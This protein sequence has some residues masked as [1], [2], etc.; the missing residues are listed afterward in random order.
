[1]RLMP[2]NW[3]SFQHYKDRSP[4]WIK[5]HR[6]LLDSIDYHNLSPEA[7]KHLPLIWLLASERD[8]VLPDAD[9]VAFRFRITEEMAT[10]ILDELL[11]LDF[12]VEVDADDVDFDSP[13]TTSKKIAQKNGFGSRHIKDKTKKEIFERD[14]GCC[15]E[16]KSDQNIEYDHILPVSAGGSSEKENIQLLCRSCNRRKRARITA[17]QVATNGNKQR[18]PEK[19]TS[20]NK[21]QGK[22]EKESCPKNNSDDLEFNEFYKNYPRHEGRGQA[23]KAYLTARKKASAEIL[24]AGSIRAREKYGDTEAKYIPLPATWLNGERWL[25]ET[26]SPK[27]YSIENDPAYRGAI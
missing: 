17:E 18:S 25:D 23:L 3:E 21:V 19:R 27:K 15:K 12:L 8:G 7:G 5:L 14:G 24:L 6:S 20:K 9:R 10:V 26:A 13:K 2:K 22:T 1:M 11:R 4:I 16:C